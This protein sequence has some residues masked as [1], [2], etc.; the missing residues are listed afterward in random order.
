MPGRW[1]VN[2]VS[3]RECAAEKLTEMVCSVQ[4]ELLSYRINVIL[5]LAPA[6]S[7]TRMG[8]ADYLIIIYP[9][10]AR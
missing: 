4:A 8:G 2:S 6:K 9:L 3:F 10:A 7:E 5:L 1:K